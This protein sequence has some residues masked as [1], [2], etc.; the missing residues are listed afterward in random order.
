MKNHEKKNEKYEL[1]FKF[2]H[3]NYDSTG[4][5]NFHNFQIL[6][7][8][9]IKIIVKNSTKVLPNHTEDTKE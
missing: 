9:L 5:N 1:F 8:F 4:C 2:L 6:L 3:R 7:C